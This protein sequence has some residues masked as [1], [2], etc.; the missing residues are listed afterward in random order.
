[1]TVEVMT[2]IS[3][4]SIGVGIYG[5]IVGLRRNKTKDD[6][7]EASEITTVIIK[8]ENISKDLVEIKQEFRNEIKTIKT[9]AAAS[10]DD[11]IRIDASLKSAWNAINE[12]K[13][14]FTRICINEKEKQN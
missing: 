9:E 13:G 14:N 12:L 3:A 8:L 7:A 11:I 1:M 6:K 5:S 10:H 2:V 4:V